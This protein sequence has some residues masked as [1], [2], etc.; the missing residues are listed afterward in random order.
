LLKHLYSFLNNQ[1]RFY[2]EIRSS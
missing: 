2:G 1:I